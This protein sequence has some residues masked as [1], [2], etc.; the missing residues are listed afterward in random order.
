MG[1]S[2]IDFSKAKQTVPYISKP[3]TY[4]V[5][6]TEVRVMA[7]EKGECLLVTFKNQ[8]GE[9]YITRYYYEHP[10]ESIAAL[11]IKL[12][13]DLLKACDLKEGSSETQLISKVLDI[14]LDYD[15]KNPKYMRLI[16][17]AKYQPNPFEV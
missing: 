10:V 15:T 12:A 6:I 2:N 4:T 14:A 9:I 7:T 16:N 5:I 3:G 1:L 11:N 8:A 17:V 13:Q